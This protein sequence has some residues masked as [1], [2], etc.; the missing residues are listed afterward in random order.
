MLMND[1][2][3]DD[4]QAAVTAVVAAQVGAFPLP[5]GSADA[6]VVVTLPPGGYT[7]HASGKDGSTGVALV[8]VYLVP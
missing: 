6:A 7:L 4:A 5:V 1:D 8:E 2:W 3:G